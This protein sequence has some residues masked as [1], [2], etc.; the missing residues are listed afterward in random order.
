VLLNA[1]EGR[2]YP[3]Y[4]SSNHL[5]AETETNFRLP[6]ILY[7]NQVREALS[8]LTAQISSHPD[9]S[10]LHPLILPNSKDTLPEALTHLAGVILSCPAFAPDTY[11]LPLQ[12]AVLE[13][14]LVKQTEQIFWLETAIATLLS[15]GDI[16][17]DCP[18]SPGLTLVIQAGA[19]TTEF[20][21]VTIP[22]KLQSLAH[23]DFCLHS[24][25]YGGNHLDQDILCQLLYPQWVSQLQPFLPPLDEELPEPGKPDLPRRHTLS[26]RL[27]SHPIGHAFLEAGKLVKLILQEE[28]ELTSHLGNQP[29]SVKRQ[30]LE[31]EVIKPL[32]RQWNDEIDSLLTQSGNTKKAIGQ[33][34]CSGG[35]TLALGRALSAWLTDQFPQ[36]TLI[37]SIEE[38][39]ATD[40]AFGLARLPLFPKLGRFLVSRAQS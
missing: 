17:A 3:I 29:W 35:T 2:L 36:A 33:I 19:T 16:K 1:K 20:A 5:K 38:G 7:G 32:L 15:H 37:Q 39:I 24:M 21:L 23:T 4:W 27:Q 6:A 26:L 40:V 13:A 10:P 22:D 9:N 8:T 34:I 11:R 30:A 28:A 31:A 12:E 25:A 18:V 14:Q